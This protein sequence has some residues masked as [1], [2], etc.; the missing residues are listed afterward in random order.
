MQDN[1][2]TVSSEVGLQNDFTFREY[3]FINLM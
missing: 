3:K 1:F 2:K